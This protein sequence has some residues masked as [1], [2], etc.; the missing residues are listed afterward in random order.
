MDLSGLSIHGEV[1]GS[2]ATI[3][4]QGIPL[5]SA[6]C[7]CQIHGSTHHKAGV[8]VFERRWAFVA[9]LTKTASLVAALAVH[10]SVIASGLID[11]ITGGTQLIGPP[12]GANACHTDPILHAIAI[13]ALL[14][15]SG[16]IARTAS[17]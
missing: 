14:T 7:G 6:R 3:S 15:L 2:K 17:T 8:R 13:Q 11:G 12:C 5:G 1:V 9:P 4:I 16:G 10:W